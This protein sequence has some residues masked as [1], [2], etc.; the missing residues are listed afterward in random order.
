M[1]A[2]PLSAVTRRDVLKAGAAGAGLVLAIQLAGCSK[3]GGGA[4][5]GERQL[6]TANAWLRIGSDDSIT[7]LCDRSEMGQGVYTALPTLLA[8]ELDVDPS[9]LTIEFAPVGDAY[10]NGA[11]GAQVTGGSTSVRDAWQKLRTAGAQAR[12]MLKAAA[13]KEWDTAASACRVE[14][15]EIVSPY[16]KRL[17]Y[18]AVAA[19][20]AAIPVPTDVELKDPQHFRWIGKTV[21]RLDTP[22]KVDGS[23]TFGIDVR[24]PGMLYAAL[25]QPPMLGGKVKAL[26]DSVAKAMPGV[27]QIVTTGSGIAVVA[28]TWWQAR[29]ARDALKIDWDGTASAGLND[30]SILRGLRQ[31]SAKPGLVARTVG[32]AEAALK[33]AARVVRAEYELPLLAHATMEPQ[34]CTADVRADG[35]DIHVP[36][37][38]QAA[39]QAAAAT[40]AGLKPGQ[41]EVHTTFLGGGFGRRIDVDFIPAAV[42]ASK[43]VGKPVKLLW[44]REDDTTHD[45]Y[46]PPACDTVAGGFDR[47]GKLI[48]WKLHLTGPSITARVFPGA[49]PAGAV[50]P[51]AVEAAANYPYDVPNVLVDWVPHEIGL[52]V[53]YWRSVSHSLNC[54]VAESF[55]DELALAAGQDPAEFRRALLAKQPRYLEVLEV[56]LRRS[57]YGKPAP[58]RYF[59][60]AAMEGYDTYMAQVA[61]ISLAGGK[62]KVEK[63]V[64]A[65]DCGRTVNPGIVTAQVES[66]ILF[67]LSAALWGEI[68]VQGG[69]VQQSNF[70]DYRIVRMNEVPQIETY[71]VPS[72]SPPGGIGEPATALVAPAV[73][74]ALFTATRRRLRSLPIARHKLA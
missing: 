10:K 24:L 40:A 56:A 17:R 62:V 22:A 1:S 30:G 7:F 32:D 4:A 25:A 47:D 66:S 55:M 27:R 33:A 60:V 36:T 44:T 67:G 16:G 71:Q 2:L 61:E 52:D 29:K 5:S 8:E 21:P 46:R 45:V 69:R 20:A 49:V 53:G 15:G 9:R 42:E 64:C 35:C 39:A 73:C 41:V 50:D 58:G 65:L 34:V 63:I 68:N 3:P 19:S 26:D 74:N 23:A 18:G 72:D 59:G 6:F 37:Q 13:A 57:G 31:A 38:S 48:A 43:A 70:H 28:D 14:N 12:E 51:F 54:F 11:I